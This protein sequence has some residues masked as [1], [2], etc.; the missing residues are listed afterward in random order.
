[1][2]GVFILCTGFL[3]CCGALRESY[4]MICTFSIIIVI[5]LVV[6]LAGGIAGYILRD[7]IED[8][9][10]KN[11]LKLMAEY[12]KT[13]ST[14]DLFDK[15]QQ[16]FDCCGTD[17][18]TEWAKYL[19]P[20]NVPDSCCKD[21]SANCGRQYSPGSIYTDSCKDALFDFL[22]DN[23]VVIAAIAIAVALIQ[24]FG[25]VCACCLIRSIKSEYEV[26]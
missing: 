26:V 15:V 25:V 13:E 9:I 16:T 2:V 1:V 3:G 5:L 21:E 17:N 20:D 23:I 7:D 4:C 19:G 8:Q 6:E 22:A 14:T 24:I 10:G 12:N 11:M 18:A